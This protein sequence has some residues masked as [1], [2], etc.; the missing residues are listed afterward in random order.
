MLRC[1]SC[2]KDLDYEI[3]YAEWDENE[4]I[5]V[6]DTFYFCEECFEELQR[7][8]KRGDFRIRINGEDF[9][10]GW[11]DRYRKIE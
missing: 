5:F 9:Y 6:E 7:I 1:D 11:L 3:A 8:R 4:G 2:G 10:T